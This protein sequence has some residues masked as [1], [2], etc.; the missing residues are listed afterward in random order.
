MIKNLWQNT[1][2]CCGNHPHE[3]N[4]VEM[5]I[6]DGPS[7]PF[8]ACP[9]YY[10]ENRNEMERACANRINFVDFEKFIDHISEFIEE[11]NRNKETPALV[12]HI[13]KYKTI[14]FEVIEYKYGNIKVKMLNRKALK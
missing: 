5:N 10:P 1:K 7:S 14:T 4:V 9:K 11:A 2:I 13:W 12:G 3:E 6:Q 8:Y